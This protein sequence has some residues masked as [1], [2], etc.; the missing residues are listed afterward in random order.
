MIQKQKEEEEK[1]ESTTQIVSYVGTKNEKLSNAAPG[2]G[3]ETNIQDI[4]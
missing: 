4:I 2:L 3:E 1:E